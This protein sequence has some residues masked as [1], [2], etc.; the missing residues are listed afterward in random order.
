MANLSKNLKPGAKVALIEF[1]E[2]ELPQGPPEA[3]KIPKAKMI[4]LAKNAGLKLVEEKDILPY[5][6]FL[7]FTKEAK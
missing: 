4:E 3:M 2:G 5:Q 6:N 7:I 1:K